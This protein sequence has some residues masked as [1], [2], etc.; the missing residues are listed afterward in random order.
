M[1][2]RKLDS[3]L[4]CVVLCRSSF[5]LGI[6]FGAARC[7][8]IGFMALD[9][10]LLK[11]PFLMKTLSSGVCRRKA[12]SVVGLLFL[13]LLLLLLFC[14]TTTDLFP[15]III[16]GPW[17]TEKKHPPCI[18]RWFSLQKRLNDLRLELLSEEGRSQVGIGWDWWY[19]SRYPTTRNDLW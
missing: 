18:R 6:I 8:W 12:G 11:S 3:S 17:F 9:Q 15:L 1:G 4:S 14:F 13:L 5:F 16:R 7:Q 2:L 19:L 10:I